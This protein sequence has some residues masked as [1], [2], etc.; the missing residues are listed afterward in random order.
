MDAMDASR[1]CRILEAASVFD[2]CDLAQRLIR[3]GVHLLASDPEGHRVLVLFCN[4]AY[5]LSRDAD[6]ISIYDELTKNRQELGQSL[7]NELGLESI[8][9]VTDY[10]GNNKHFA[11]L[12]Q[13]DLLV[14]LMMTSVDVKPLITFISSEKV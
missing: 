6:L 4:R 11:G 10:S 2:L 14:R 8:I 12:I 7:L 13:G 1:F 9:L 5:E 3:H